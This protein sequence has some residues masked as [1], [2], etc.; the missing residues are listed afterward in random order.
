MRK[1]FLFV[2]IFTLSLIAL[3]SAVLAGGDKVHGEKGEGP[4]TQQCVNFDDCP[5]GDEAPTL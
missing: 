4:T 1:I 2:S 3:S 5:Y